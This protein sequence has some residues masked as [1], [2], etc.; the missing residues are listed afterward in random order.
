MSDAMPTKVWLQ[1]DGWYTERQPPP[2]DKW[3]LR[4]YRRADLVDAEIE[5]LRSQIKAINSSMDHHAQTMDAKLVERD[6]EIDRLRAEVERL[7]Q[8]REGEY[9]RMLEWRGIEHGNE[10]K[11]CGGAGVTTYGSTATWRGGV[12]GQT[13]TAGIC[14]KCWGSGQHTRP[15]LSLRKLDAER[16]R[17]RLPEELVE[18]IRTAVEYDLQ[19]QFGGNLVKRIL[20][21]ILAAVEPQT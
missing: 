13:I 5:R 9:A 6:A 21:D 11:G 18:R 1:D 20:E 17:A 2:E 10:C 19:E 16:Q 4:E 15:W 7:R 3:R 8:R 12:G 14:D